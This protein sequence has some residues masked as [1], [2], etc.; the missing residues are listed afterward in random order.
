MMGSLSKRVPRAAIFLGANC[1]GVVLSIALLVEPLMSH[2]SSRGDDIRE[3]AAQLAYYRHIVKT[4]QIMEQSSS[5]NSQPFL[6]GGEDRV[7]SADLQAH[8][9]TVAIAKGARILGLRGLQ[10][11]RLGQLRTVAVGLELEGSTSVLRDL[12]AEIEA[13][14]PFLFVTEASLRAV[15]DGDGNMLRAELRVEGAVR[16]TR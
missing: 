14:S 9:Q 1:A 3:N 13:Q 16:G 11:G 12:M 4:A 2:F 8:L 10:S 5:Q 6:V 7:I 15:A